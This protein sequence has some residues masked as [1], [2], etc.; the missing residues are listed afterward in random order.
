M[1]ITPKVARYLSIINELQAA[2]LEV[3]ELN[4]HVLLVDGLNTFFRA[5]SASPVRNADGEHVGGISSFLLSIG[6]IIKMVKPTR[7]IIAWDGVGGSQ[8]RRS[9]H[10]DYKT[11]R[12]PIKMLNRS[13]DF[14]YT[15]DEEN[16]QQRRQ[17]LRLVDFI[18]TLPITTI[19]VDGVEADDIIGYLASHVIDGKVTIMSGDKDF[20]QLVN[21]R[22]QV[23][24]PTKKIMINEITVKD[25]TGVFPCNTTLVRSV[26]G[27][28]KSDNI[29]GVPRVGSKT[30]LKA[31]PQ[32]CEPTK[33][34]LPELMKLA[35][36]SNTRIGNLLIEHEPIINRNIQL[37]SLN[38]SDMALSGTL[39]LDIFNQ[40]QQI[41]EKT[42]QLKFFKLLVNDKMELAIKNVYVWIKE[43]FDPLNKFAK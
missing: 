3:R 24:S 30:L 31:F 15:P 39:K 4:S 34:I 11:G 25:L 13:A 27:D 23:W 1:H 32:L 29:S 26:I 28:D 21:D 10:K 35:R 36:E 7:I 22:V 6:S 18:D 41:P 9:I 8:R 14:E 17:L 33:I 40:F 5:Y 43:V 2:D 12:K 37:S 38:D 20:Y 42:K 16:E 19:N